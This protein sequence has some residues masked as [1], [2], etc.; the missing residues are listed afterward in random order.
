MTA[1]EGPAR[2]PD[3]SGAKLALFHGPRLLTLQRDDRPGLPWAGMW[4]LP[5]GGREGRETPEACALREL[6]EEFGL[7]L[8]EDR[9]LSRLCVPAMA[10]PARRAWFFTGR[11]TAAEVA[12]IRFGPEG[13]GWAL[14]PVKVFLCHPAAIPALQDRVRRLLTPD[15]LAP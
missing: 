11:L 7:S 10:D 12:A 2:A 8:G 14:M 3:F 13:Q 5:G 4:D 9:L 6:H 15:L 1:P